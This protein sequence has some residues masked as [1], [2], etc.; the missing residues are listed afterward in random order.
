[1]QTPVGAKS[2]TKQPVVVVLTSDQITPALLALEDMPTGYAAIPAPATSGPNGTSGYCNGPNEDARAAAQGG[3]GSGIVGFGQNPTY[4][5][6]ITESVHSFPTAKQ[7]A[8]ALAAV[9]PQAGCGTYNDASSGTTVTRT[10]API[11]YS[12]VGDGTVALRMSSSLPGSTGTAAS[13]DQITVQLMNNLITITNG[14]LAGPTTSTEQ[15]MIGKSITKLGTAIEAAK[16]VQRQ[17]A[18]ATTTTKPKGKK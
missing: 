6:F 7:A 13:T 17:A 9:T 5:P 3:V 2:K 16:A 18:A 11:A 1:M 8:A 12:K 14:G 4:G 10:I 15:D